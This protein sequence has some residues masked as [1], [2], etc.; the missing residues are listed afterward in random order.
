MPPA[1]LWLNVERWFGND[2]VQKEHYQISAIGGTVAGSGSGASRSQWSVTWQGDAL[3]MD[4]ETTGAT[5]T[6]RIEMWRLDESGRLV[7]SLQR[8]D[9]NQAETQTATYQKEN[10]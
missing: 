4:W 6:H 5:R 7:V 3:R 8:T 2:D 1:Y 9:G 10:Q